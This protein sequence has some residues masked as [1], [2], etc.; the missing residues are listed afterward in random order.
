MTILSFESTR[1]L[2]YGRIIRGADGTVEAIVEDRDAIPEQKQIRELNSS[3]YVF[4]AAP[5]WKALERLDRAQ[6]A[7]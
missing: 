6:R 4:A 7:G 5:L 3:T 1:P 2:P